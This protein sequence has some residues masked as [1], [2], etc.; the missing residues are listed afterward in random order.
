MLTLVDQE[1]IPVL[2]G[3]MKKLGLDARLKTPFESVEKLDNGMYQVNLSDG[4][5]I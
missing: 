2:Q 4:T 3:S 5:N 1:L